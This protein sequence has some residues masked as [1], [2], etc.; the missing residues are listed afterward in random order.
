MVKRN[1]LKITVLKRTDP[2]EFF[3]I[4]PVTVQDWF[5][6]CDTYKDGEVFMVKENLQMPK[7]FCE[8]AWHAIYPTIRTIGFGGNLPY[9]KEEGTAISCCT[10]RMRPVVF[11]IERI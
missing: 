4:L 3:K 5:V 9:F 6:P 7:G 2:K 11:Q 10:D 8:S 1:K